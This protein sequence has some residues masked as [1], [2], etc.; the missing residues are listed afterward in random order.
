MLY[1]LRETDFRVKDIVPAAAAATLSKRFKF[2]LGGQCWGGRC[3][4]GQCQSTNYLIQENVFS[5]AYF[6]FMI[7]KKLILNKEFAC[8]WNPN[9]FYQNSDVTAGDV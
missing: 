6:Y 2:V 9:Y 8:L 3:R 7:L 4:G 5:H 1:A